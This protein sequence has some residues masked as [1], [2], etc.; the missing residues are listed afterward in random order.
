MQTLRKVDILPMS[1]SLQA[2]T[3]YMPAELIRLS[4]GTFPFNRRSAGG[5]RS[6]GVVSFPGLSLTPA[7]NRIQIAGRD[8]ISN[9]LGHRSLLLFA[10]KIV[11]LPH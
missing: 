1:A 3:K 5:R 10:R 11:E 2:P 4:G 9:F 7:R 6:Y 8:L